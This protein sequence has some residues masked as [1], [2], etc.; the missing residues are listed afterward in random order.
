[1]FGGERSGLPRGAR[2]VQG[3]QGGQGGQGGHSGAGTAQH[4]LAKTQTC[5]YVK[6]WGG[7]C[8]C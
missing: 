5:K 2:G 8:C 6:R 4:I 1:M 7:E 3:V